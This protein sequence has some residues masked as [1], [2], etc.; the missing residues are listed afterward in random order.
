VVASSIKSLKGALKVLH[1]ALKREAPTKYPNG[2]DGMRGDHLSPGLAV[3]HLAPAKVQLAVFALTQ[4]NIL[5]AFE[6]L[7]YGPG[8]REKQVVDGV[9][10]RHAQLKRLTYDLAAGEPVQT[11]DV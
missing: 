2:V 7:E 6:A 8:K 5:E 4:P 9:R 1:N 3:V 10:M 11:A